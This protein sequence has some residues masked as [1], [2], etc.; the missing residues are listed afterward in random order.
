VLVH[1]VRERVEE[2]GASV[3]RRGALEARH[4]QRSGKLGA[5]DVE[6]G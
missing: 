4:P 1:D 3:E 6:F 5:F 2:F